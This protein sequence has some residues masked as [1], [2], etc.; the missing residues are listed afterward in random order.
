M[1][2]ERLQ[3]YG[4][5]TRSQVDYEL[6]ERN[7]HGAHCHETRR[8][9]E[10]DGKKSMRLYMAPDSSCIPLK[11]FGLW[12]NVGGLKGVVTPVTTDT[13]QFF[14]GVRRQWDEDPGSI[15]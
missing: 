4:G 7:F 1:I 5:L 11:R 2:S 9:V 10:R 6:G 8:R 3:I 13:D 12:Q 14:P 15:G